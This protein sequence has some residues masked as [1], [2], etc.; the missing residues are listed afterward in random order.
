M[1]WFYEKC[2]ETVA[3]PLHGT[4]DGKVNGYL[5]NVQEDVAFYLCVVIIS[6]QLCGARFPTELYTRGCHWIPR[7]FA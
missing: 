5:M 1:L 2:I 7:L 3:Q 6:V 4:H